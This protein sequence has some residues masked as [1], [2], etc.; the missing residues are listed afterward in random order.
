MTESV[1]LLAPSAGL[2]GGIE[3]Y[4]ST[5]EGAFQQY[6]VAYRRLDLVGPGRPGGL[7][8][9]LAFLRETLRAVRTSPGPVRLVVAH[10]H[11]L[12][13]VGLVARMRNFAGATTI[14]YGCEIWSGRRPRGW[15][16]MRRADVRLVTISNFSAGALAGAC[17]ANVNILH[18]GISPEW[19]ATLVNA[20][21]RARPVTDE[22]RLVTAFRLEDWRDK[23]LDTL[24]EAVRRLDDDRIRLT[25]C[26]SG[27]V[28]P[29][30]TQAVAGLP[31]CRIEANLTDAGLAE[32][33]ADADLCVLATRTRYGDDA[34]GEGFGL[35]L[36]EAQ[37]AGT[38]VVAP[39]YGGSG[40]TF[41]PGLTGLA[42]ADESPGALA[43]TL[44]SLLHNP[45]RRTELGHTAAAWSRARFQPGRYPPVVAQA[46]LGRS[47]RSTPRA[48]T[49]QRSLA[50]ASTH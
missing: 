28:P 36:V 29:E 39:A 38:P 11:L 5:V 43:A 44:T 45:Q 47:I 27:A 46:L 18:P 41:Q 24:L 2:G 10:N 25:V 21:K 17:Q 13:V 40:D 3:R 31:W 37:L 50:S 14:L 9:K 34:Y 15:R 7:R 20:G 48:G 26:G 23:G 12:P 4:L 30:L 49:D 16:T 32:R 42:P 35:V 33:L 1:L 8:G 19:Y 6:G 22:L